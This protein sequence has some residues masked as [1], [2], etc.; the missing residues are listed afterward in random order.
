MKIFKS[1]ETL[2][3]WSMWI[4]TLVF[5]SFLMGLGGKIIA[6]LP[7]AT[8]A[9]SVYDFVGT[10]L[11][12]I[13]EHLK[14]LQKNEQQLKGSIDVQTKE[15][16]TAVNNYRAAKAA[17]QAWLDT[18][19][20]TGNNQSTH[21]GDND[22]K[23][24]TMEL[25]TLNGLVRESQSKKELLEKEQLAT[26]Q[27]MSQL[28]DQRQVIVQ[29]AHDQVSSAQRWHEFVVFAYRLLITL[30]LIAISIYFIRRKRQSSY[31]PLARGFVLFSVVTF[32]SELV[33]YLPSYGGYVR[34]IM[35]LILCIGAGHYGIRWM[36]Q[37]IAKRQLEIERGEI[38]RRASL[39][40]E[41]ALDKMNAQL[42]PSCDHKIP[43]PLNGVDVNHCV[44]CGL[45]LFKPCS[46][47]GV[48]NNAFY[49]HCAACGTENTD[50]KAP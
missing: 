34:Y 30:P 7:K 50:A 38:E 41:Q 6:D 31:W 45:T 44:H 4:V 21:A 10:Q 39:N 25:D 43:A 3:K 16:E 20:A 19:V 9:P 28:Q 40:T 1:P 29:A 15:L 36:Q 5:S 2:Y 33:P 27:M 37:Y 18:R 35:G 26:S 17:H 24:R 47:C 12:P 13:D 22:L 48:R 14:E 46:H 42:C 23:T 49:K 11:Q 32:F 8:H